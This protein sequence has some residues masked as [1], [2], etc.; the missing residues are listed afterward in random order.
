MLRQG[1]DLREGRDD[2]VGEARLGHLLHEEGT[3][4]VVGDHGAEAV[5]DHHDAVVAGDTVARALV[6]QILEDLKAELPD[7]VARLDIVR[8]IAQVAGAVTD[9]GHE[10]HPGEKDEEREKDEQPERRRW[11]AEREER[12]VEQPA[13]DRPGRIA[14]AEKTPERT[15]ERDEEG[16]PRRADEAVRRGDGTEKHDEARYRRNQC[17]QRQRMPGGDRGEDGEEAREADARLPTL[18][19]P[20]GREGPDQGAHHQESDGSLGARHCRRGRQRRARTSR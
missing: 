14:E 7:A 11:M 17:Q 10:E 8:G 19:E 3:Q 2:L 4:H 15:P 13:V 6:V 9:I 1:I 12:H 20:E 5:G 18:L 16:K